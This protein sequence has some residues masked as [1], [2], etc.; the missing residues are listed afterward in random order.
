M[1]KMFKISLTLVLGQVSPKDKVENK[2][3]SAKELEKAACKQVNGEAAER[4]EPLTVI[5]QILGS[6]KFS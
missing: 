3:S 2:C 1:R 5:T 4:E 6:A